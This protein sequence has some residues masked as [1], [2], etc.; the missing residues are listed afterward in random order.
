[1]GKHGS[2]CHQ[3]SVTAWT[4]YPLLQPKQTRVACPPE[5]SS[6]PIITPSSGQVSTTTNEAFNF[7]EEVF[8]RFRSDDTD[9][10]QDGAHKQEI[11]II[12]CVPFLVLNYAEKSESLVAHTV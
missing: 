12:Y 1:M 8:A 11:S 7:K 5:F 6:W 10:S 4:F 3:S 9:N 2:S